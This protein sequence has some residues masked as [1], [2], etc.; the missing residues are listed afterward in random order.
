MFLDKS[1]GHLMHYLEE[2]GWM[3]NSI[4]V[5]ASDNGGDSSEAGSNYPLRGE[6]ASYWEGGCKAR[7]EKTYSGFA[8]LLR[9][10][11][12]HSWVNTP[13]ICLFPRF[14][15]AKLHQVDPR[16]VDVALFSLKWRSDN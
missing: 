2:K 7:S 5:V 9:G 13:T 8:C 14:L 11:F 16:L 12:S 10:C 3:E 4:V 15:G 6:K 1:I